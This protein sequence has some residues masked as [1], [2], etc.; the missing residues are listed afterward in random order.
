MI[1]SPPRNSL[2]I[3]SAD[4]AEI[5]S[6]IIGMR[7]KCATSWDNI[8]A[9]VIKLT[10]NALTLPITHI[11]NLATNTG[12]FPDVFKKSCGTSYFWGWG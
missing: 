1:P 3:L 10:K 7:A 6:I 8:P 5:E 2:S 4:V 12:S 11:C 9:K